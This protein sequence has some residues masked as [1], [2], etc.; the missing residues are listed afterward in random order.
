MTDGNLKGLKYEEYFFYKP[1]ENWQIRFIKHLFQKQPFNCYVLSF[2]LF[3]MKTE[4][5]FE[6]LE[7]HFAY[8]A[9]P[10]TTPRGTISV[11][12]KVSE[13][14]SNTPQ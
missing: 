10:T 4:K 3:L 2:S 11:P 13:C 9:N 6:V 8:T 7:V 1:L 5:M 14:A 12:K